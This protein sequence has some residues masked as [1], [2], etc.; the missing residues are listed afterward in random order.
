MSTPLFQGLQGYDRVSTA[1]GYLESS[2]N[3]R[4]LRR[5]ADSILKRD[6]E[7]FIG[8][9][10]TNSITAEFWMRRETLER[11]SASQS[12]SD[13]LKSSTSSFNKLT[14]GADAQLGNGLYISDNHFVAYNYAN[15]NV[16]MNRGTEPRVRAIFARSSNEWRNEIVKVFI[17][18]MFVKDA[19]GKRGTEFGA[20][21]VSYLKHVAFNTPIENIVRISRID[22][23]RENLRDMNQLLV[24]SGIATRFSA[25]CTDP[26]APSTSVRIPPVPLNYLSPQLQTAW[27]VLGTEHA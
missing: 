20:H 3:P 5:I 8:W 24:R 15:G 22:K 19:P 2:S 1:N 18:D 12:L 11:P 21:R 4:D 26:A 6:S 27:K 16:A 25:L 13:Y 23:T 14:S 7:E 17:P 9:H 10:G